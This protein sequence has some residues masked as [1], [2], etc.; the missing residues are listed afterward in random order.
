MALNLAL[1]VAS[2]TALEWEREWSGSEKEEEEEADEMSCFIE[3]DQ[4]GDSDEEELSQNRAGRIKEAFAYIDQLWDKVDQAQLEVTERDDIIA[5][6]QSQHIQTLAIIEERDEEMRSMTK[7]E[8]EC[9]KTIEKLRKEMSD[10]RSTL[11]DEKVSHQLLAHQW[12]KEQDVIK[13]E[14]S[15]MSSKLKQARD[16]AALTKME[17]QDL[18]ETIASLRADNQQL[19]E[20][21]EKSNSHSHKTI[22]DQRQ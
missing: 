4:N 6:M 15:E 13:A 20:E 10:L 21:K 14:K 18:M 3:E 22:D 11:S 12:E 17:V 2:N 7:R 19:T 8:K 9:E 1:E 16:E 5:K